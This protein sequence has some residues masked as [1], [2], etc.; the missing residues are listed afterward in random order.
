MVT[1]KQLK[2]KYPGAIAWPFGD[3]PQMSAE[4]A[5]LV[6][7]GL[8]TAGCGSLAAFEKEE[9]SPTIGGYN[10][11]LDG[12]GRP[13]CVIRT[14]AM[15]LIRFNEVTEELARKEGEG[16]LS[17]QYWRREHKEFF[18]REGTFSEN[19]E[20]VAEEFELIEIVQTEHR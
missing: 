18:E 3:S 5:G 11:I 13:I 19:M 7:R 10:I 9:D 4:L 16:D 2:A 1:V 12:E 14:I 20:L 6:V 15:R 17:L 8:K